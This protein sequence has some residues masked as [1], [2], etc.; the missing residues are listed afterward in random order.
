M[1]RSESAVSGAASGT[2]GEACS[3]TRTCAGGGTTA[4]GGSCDGTK[5]I[6]RADDGR[7][8]PPARPRAGARG[9]GPPPPPQAR[10]PARRERPQ[11]RV[12]RWLRPAAP[13]PEPALDSEVRTLRRP[14]ALVPTT[15]REPRRRRGARPAPPERGSAVWQRPA[16]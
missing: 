8:A 15:N 1:R 14:L 2:F 4:A 13:Y 5:A 11:P 9:A 10:C 3:A 16:G 6:R 7:E 12:V